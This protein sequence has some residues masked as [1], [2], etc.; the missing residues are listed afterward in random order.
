MLSLN[1]ITKY[2]LDSIIQRLNNWTQE[3]KQIRE[4]ITGPYLNAEV[5]ERTLGRGGWAGIY[6]D[7]LWSGTVGSRADLP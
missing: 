6:V 7:K 3:Y 4:I 2:P 1:W 5:G